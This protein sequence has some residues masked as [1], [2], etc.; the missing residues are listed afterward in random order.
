L[1]PFGVVSESTESIGGRA[2]RKGNEVLKVRPLGSEGDEACDISVSR[3]EGLPYRDLQDINTEM[4]GHYRMGSFVPANVD[5]P[6]HA[7]FR[8]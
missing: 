1:V 4:K 7:A 2:G 8:R 6:D 5:R 3:V